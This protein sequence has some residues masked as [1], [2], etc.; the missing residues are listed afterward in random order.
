MKKE[1]TKDLAYYRENAEEDFMTTPISVL[2]Y[3]A[4]LELK[5]LKI[6][7]MLN[8]ICEVEENVFLRMDIEQLIKEATPYENN[9]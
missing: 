5:A 4:E 1:E 8:R 9:N 6:R 2:R 3:I 7:E